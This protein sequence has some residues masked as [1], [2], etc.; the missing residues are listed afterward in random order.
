MFAGSDW[1]EPH[2]GHLHGHDESQE[3]EGGV[4]HVDA[5]GEPAHQQEHKDVEGDQVDDEHIATPG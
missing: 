1:L 4:G 5:G 3:V 2:E